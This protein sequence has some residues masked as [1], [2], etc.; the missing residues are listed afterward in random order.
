[1]RL[2]HKPEGNI[3]QN[4]ENTV[5]PNHSNI[6][7]LACHQDPRL[8]KTHLHLSQKEQK[9]MVSGARDS[10]NLYQQFLIKTGPF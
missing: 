9:F 3:D 4:P 6:Q 8:L 7:S 10:K 2:L 1:M 5:W